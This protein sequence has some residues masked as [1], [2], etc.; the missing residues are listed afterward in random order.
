MDPVTI[1]DDPLR[2]SLGAYLLGALDPADRADVEAHLV[3]CPGCREELASLAGLP[4]LLSRLTADE[5]AATGLVGSPAEPGT[6]APG[7]PGPALLER[8]LHE[9]VRARQRQRRRWLSA[10]AAAVLI[11]GGGVA[12]VTAA[13]GSGPGL[14]RPGTAVTGAVTTIAATDPTTHVSARVSLR[15]EPA[16][17]AITLSLAGVTP[18]VHCQLVA[19]A[20]DGHREVASSWQA[21]Y[22]GNA[23]VTGTTAVPTTELTALQIVT[24]DGRQLVSVPVHG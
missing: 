15:G 4:G 2:L 14:G 23:D 24:T 7:K 6:T 19:V 18:G 22:D 10:A 17:T 20:A 13:T 16:G 5:A 9:V 8:V 1:H 21:A 12:A 11:A 3:H